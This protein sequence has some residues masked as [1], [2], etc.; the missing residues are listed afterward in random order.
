MLIECFLFQGALASGHADDAFTAAGWLRAPAGVWRPSQKAQRFIYDSGRH[1][2][3]G[4][5]PELLPSKTNAEYLKACSERDSFY[6]GLVRCTRVQ[7]GPNSSSLWHHAAA[8]RRVYQSPV[9]KHG[10]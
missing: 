5:L 4:E 3:V 8:I 6:S 1:E 7:S 10:P 9:V 2:H